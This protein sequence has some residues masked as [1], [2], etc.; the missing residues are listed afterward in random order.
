[1][2]PR[3]PR[4]W[5]AGLLAI[6]LLALGG[7]N[8]DV[9]PDQAPKLWVHVR[10]VPYEPLMSMTLHIVTKAQPQKF[11]L[12]VFLWRYGKH[13]THHV[14]RLWVRG[15]KDI[16]AVGKGKTLNFPDLRKLDKADDLLVC[17]DGSY[18]A[19]W[20]VHGVNSDGSV[21]SST[22]YYPYDI[23]KVPYKYPPSPKRSWHVKCDK[24][25]QVPD[26]VGERPLI[27]TVR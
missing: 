26:P 13:R 2:P 4:R 19:Q 6:P 23:T 27:I 17:D 25:G 15:I 22:F 8:F 9:H 20:H 18:F 16:P 1:M 24:N 21:Q 3:P 14:I 11:S 5:L 7:C 10:P 12:Y